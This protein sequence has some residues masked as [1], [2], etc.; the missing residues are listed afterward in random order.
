MPTRLRSLGPYKAIPKPKEDLPPALVM[1]LT[2]KKPLNSR[3]SD[4]DA[5]K[6][7]S[8]AAALSGY[9]KTE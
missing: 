2:S 7:T 1:L 4:N 5:G 8:A 9:S 3:H 6:T